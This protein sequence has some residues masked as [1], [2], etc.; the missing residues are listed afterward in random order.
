MH[1]NGANPANRLFVRLHSGLESNMVIGPNCNRREA[2]IQIPHITSLANGKCGPVSDVILLLEPL[3]SGASNQIMRFRLGHKM[4]MTLLE[5]HID[6]YTDEQVVT[7]N[8]WRVWHEFRG[9]T[10]SPR[11]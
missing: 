8:D 9:M 10:E 7:L 1:Y 6:W 4:P 3:K 11:E 2:L 5:T